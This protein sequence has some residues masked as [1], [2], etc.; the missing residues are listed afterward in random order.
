LANRR[1]VDLAHG[2]PG[3]SIQRRADPQGGDPQI[4]PGSRRGSPT[5]SPSLE[6]H[7]TS[8][9]IRPPAT[10]HFRP[11]LNPYERLAVH[12]AQAVGSC[13]Q[14]A[15]SRSDPGALAV[16]PGSV[17]PL[18]SWP[19]RS[20]FER[21]TTRPDLQGRCVPDTA[22][23]RS[24]APLCCPRK[25]PSLGSHIHRTTVVDP[26]ASSPFGQTA[27]HGRFVHHRSATSGQ[28]RLVM[29]RSGVRFSSRAPRK[30]AGHDSAVAPWL[31]RRVV[32]VR[33]H[34]ASIARRPAQELGA[35]RL[36]RRLAQLGHLLRVQV[37][38]QP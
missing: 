14:R 19:D 4:R 1:R 15:R 31:F 18:L 5:G 21:S 2:R 29:R 35:H 10:S 20:Q 16:T 12:D 11:A 37:E 34:R 9:V 3:H 38:R 7:R 8:A 24:Q 33:L 36:R 17:T 32:R 28:T 30:G 27:R 25:G 22:T 26:S 6:P 13:H 23:R